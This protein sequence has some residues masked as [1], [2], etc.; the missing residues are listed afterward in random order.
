[1]RLTRAAAFRSLAGC[2]LALSLTGPALAQPR[3]A[4]VLDLAAQQKN[5]TTFVAAVH[6]AGLDDTLKAAGPITVYAPTDEAFAKLPAA[7]RDALMHD[8]ARLK[9]L[10]LGSVVN[11]MILMRD[12]DSTITSGSVP[13]AGGRSLEFGVDGDRATV[14]GAHVVTSDLKAGNGCITTIDKVLLT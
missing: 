4:T 1:M 5:L 8:P 11:D 12:G 14:G 3:P 2:L 6:A 7:D 10:L 13:T 9:A